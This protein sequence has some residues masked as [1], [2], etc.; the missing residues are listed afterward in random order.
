[1]RRGQQV[2]GGA[3]A[4]IHRPERSLLHS[5]ARFH[6][7]FGVYLYLLLSSKVSQSKDSTAARWSV[8]FLNLRHNPLCP[9]LLPF[10]LPPP[11]SVWSVRSWNLA[12]LRYRLGTN[13]E[14]RPGEP[15]QRGVPRRS[16]YRHVSASQQ[17][18]TLCPVHRKV[19]ECGE[20]GR[21]RSE[22][23]GVPGPEP[24]MQR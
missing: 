19:S 18:A 5:K 1:M 15:G 24:E 8:P 12:P 23:M 7:T 22:G 16:S 21:V 2:H 13:R 6:R 3:A 17:V 9:P 20:G 14:P 11:A 10:D 4:F